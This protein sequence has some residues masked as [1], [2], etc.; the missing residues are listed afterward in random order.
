MSLIDLHCHIL[1][2]VDDGAPDLCT[3][4]ELGKVAVD[5]GISHILLTPHH[6]DSKYINHKDRLLEKVENFQ[7]CLND[8]RIPLTVFPGQEVH[9]TG[10]IL[11]AID[12]DDV[13]FMDES[14]RYLLL[15]LPHHDIPEYTSQIVFELITR[16]ITP[17]IAH[18]ERNLA[19]QKDPEKLY[20]L[21]KMGCLT[22]LTCSSYLGG[23]GAEVRSLTENIISANLGF[24]F[25]S[26]AH[27]FDGR[28]F[29]MKQAFEKLESIDPERAQQF[30]NNAR[31]I[32]NGEDV[33]NVEPNHISSLPKKKFWLF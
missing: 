25:S 22:Q 11:K 30:K 31:N 18:P 13:I 1:P 33:N 23:F 10:D 19:I 26:D 14:S 6:M 7:A 27:N 3:A 21:V 28:R 15:E 2:G 5:Q 17:V 12:N 24:V 8:S 9:I 29:R 16:G 32:V 20:E 4:L